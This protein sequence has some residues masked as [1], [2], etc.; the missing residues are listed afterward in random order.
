M[1][2]DINFSKFVDE[3]DKAHKTHAFS[4]AGLKVIYEYLIDNK[5]INDYSAQK[6]YNEFTE[7]CTTDSVEAYFSPEDIQAFSV[8][9]KFPFGI[10][11]KEKEVLL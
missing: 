10:I 7:Y 6:I 1:C 9:I 5:D 11:V 3:F 4:R 2:K 8:I